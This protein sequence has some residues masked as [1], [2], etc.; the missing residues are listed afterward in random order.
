MSSP[1]TLQSIE[2]MTYPNL[3]LHCSNGVK[4]EASLNEHNRR[5]LDAMDTFPELEIE[6]YNAHHGML[7]ADGIAVVVYLE[8]IY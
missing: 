2:F 3:R 7:S 8:R 5:K 1:T 4:F 6:D